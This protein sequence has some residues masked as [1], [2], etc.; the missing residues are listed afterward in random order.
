MFSHNN[1]VNLDYSEIFESERDDA[2]KVCFSE[3]L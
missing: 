2:S 1:V 3:Y